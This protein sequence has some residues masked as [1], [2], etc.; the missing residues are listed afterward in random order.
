MSRSI[1]VDLCRA[2]FFLCQ[3]SVQQKWE[4]LEENQAE[5]LSCLQLAIFPILYSGD[6][7]DGASCAQNRKVALSSSVEQLVA[8]ERPGVYSVYSVYSVYTALHR[9][10]EKSN[11]LD[12]CTHTRL[13]SL[14]IFSA[15]KEKKLKQ[16]IVSVSTQTVLL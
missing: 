15:I 12:I 1:L 10:H 14:A 16:I 13:F 9:K 7:I 5:H 8:S 2:C 11:I 3:L 4:T 6:V